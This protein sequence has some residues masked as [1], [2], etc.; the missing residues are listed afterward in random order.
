MSTHEQELA[1]WTHAEQ[2][3]MR[4]AGEIDALQEAFVCLVKP[5]RTLRHDVA[6]EQA[7][8]RLSK[9]LVLLADEHVHLLDKR[10][11]LAH[12]LE[13][14]LVHLVQ[15]RGGKAEHADA[16]AQTAYDQVLAQW[17]N[18]RLALEQTERSIA[19]IQHAY[20]RLIAESQEQTEEAHE[21]AVQR[22]RLSDALD[23]LRT[24]RTRW[25]TVQAEATRA[26]ERTLEQQVH[27]WRGEV[28]HH[29]AARAHATTAAAEH[30][31]TQL[32]DEAQTEVEQHADTLADFLAAPPDAQTASVERDAPP[33]STTA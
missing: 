8:D 22:E 3:L 19:D 15:S 10:A 24:E 11:T 4:L 5:L 23:R 25:L 2:E 12:T 14:A 20:A 17:S 30:A 27:W 31:A 16:A 6:L 29:E 32:R 1:Q 18:S 13:H 33:S 28:V 9:I 21:Y 26:I 7:L